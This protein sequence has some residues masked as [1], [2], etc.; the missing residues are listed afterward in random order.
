ML[1]AWLDHYRD[2]M[3]FKIEGLDEEQARFTPT[4]TG[5]SL[6]NLIVHLAGVERGWVEGVIAGREIERDRD[7]EFGPIEL[8]LADAVA[9]F[10][11]QRERS[12]EVID[13]ASLDDR[14]EGR[15]G[16]YSVRW[17]LQHLLEEFARHAGHADITRELIDGATGYSRTEKD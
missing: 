2:I 6:L 16:T 1:R 9:G 11:A 10:R 3:I 8:T 14:M 4:A 17:V 7:A 15:Y 5:I 12:N 13:A